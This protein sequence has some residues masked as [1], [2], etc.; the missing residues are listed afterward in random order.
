MTE[1]TDWLNLI[2][3]AW[4]LLIE[5]ESLH[6]T[7]DGDCLM[8]ADDV[9]AR[10]DRYKPHLLPDARTYN[11]VV[12]AATLQGRDGPGIARFVAE[13]VLERMSEESDV[14]PLVLPT[15]VTYNRYHNCVGQEWSNGRSGEC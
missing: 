13:Q 9:L 5:T 7:H 15:K 4:R 12:V 14:N 8:E 11:M 10:L 3:D 6:T 1:M 2:V